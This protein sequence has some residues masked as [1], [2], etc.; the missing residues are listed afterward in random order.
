M[1]ALRTSISTVTPPAIEPVTLD[2]TKE[3]ARITDTADDSLIAALITTAVASIELYLRRSLITQS[4]KL[5]VN[6]PGGSDN[7]FPGYFELPVNYFDAAL[8]GNMRLPRGP[9]QS[10]ASVTT[11]DT[12]D[13]GTVYASGNY[14]LSDERLVLGTNAVWPSDLRGYG[15]T[16][17]VY[18][19]GYGDTAGDVPQPIRHAIL[20]TVAALYDGRGQCDE[21]GMAP[22]AARLL[23]PYR[24]MGDPH[25]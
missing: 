13:T 21:S 4:L 8:P 3:F 25:A 20:M 18:V 10:I 16:E 2:E 24:V 12:S 1:S 19:A 17:I 23:M 14:R 7:W 22:G 11:Y 15:A 6:L 9:V 5:T